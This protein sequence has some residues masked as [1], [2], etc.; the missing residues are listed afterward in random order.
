MIIYVTILSIIAVVLVNTVLSFTGSY[1]ELQTRR[2]VDRTAMDVLERFSRTVR[3]ST[4]IDLAS[5]VLGS[6]PGALVVVETRG[7][8]STTTRFYLDGGV[9]RMDVNGV[10]FGPL[11]LESSVV[12]SL[13]F[14][15]N[16]SG[17]SNAVRVEMS[18][19]ASMGTVVSEK[20]FFLTTTTK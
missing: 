9:V 8:I 19:S 18:I 15:I 20:N 1:R 3:A 4:S 13:V 7:A 12:E 5:S 2:M 10:Y 6:N 17:D 14:R 11:S 16:N